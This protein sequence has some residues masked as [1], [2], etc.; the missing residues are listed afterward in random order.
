MNHDITT[1]APWR[2][3]SSH[4]AQVATLHMREL[5]RNSP[6]RAIAFSLEAAGLFLD[7]SK[8]RI[9]PET[10]QRLLDLARTADVEGQRDAM[11]AGAI[12]NNTERRAVLHTALRRPASQALVLD[13]T[14]IMPG[15]AEVQRRM[16]GLVDALAGG[17]WRGYSGQRITDVVNIGIGGSHLG[18]CMAT[19]ALR[20]HHRTGLRV[21]YV[22]N[23]D[24][25]DLSHTLA[26]LHPESTLFIVVSKTFTTQETS[27][28]AQAARNWLLQS[29]GDGRAV[30]S[31]MIAVTSNVEAAQRFGIEP[32]NTFEMWEWVGGRY[33]LWSAVGLSTACAVGGDAFAEMLAGAYA[34]DSH[35]Q[36]APLEMNM[37]VALALLGV[38]YHNFF[39]AESLCVVPYDESL[40]HFPAY[41]QQLDMESNG[42]RVDR[43]GR[44]VQT[45]TGPV[46]WGGTGTNSQHAF[47]QLLHQGGRL[48]PLDLLVGLRNPRPIADQHDIL[49]ANCIAQAEALMRGRTL[50]ETRREMRSSGVEEG[51]IEQL[52]PHRVFPGN[53]PSNLIVYPELTPR[54]LGALIALY[55]HKVFVQGAIWGLNSFDQWGVELGKQLAGTVLRELQG[56]AQV[57]HDASTAALV[58]LYRSRREAGDAGD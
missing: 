24:P 6:E 22:S 43:A 51:R 37:P 40:R 54:V 13:G 7:Y 19:D 3:L 14:N 35:F 48:V 38:W 8:N 25:G 34:M 2:A 21:H 26:T 47:F 58:A 10:M 45:S 4:H 39:G 11:L 20:A 28:N 53:R 12:I 1:S 52:A 46:L 56:G 50:D 42:K 57:E 23:V 27:A 55:E 15:I 41:L 5:F 32:A 16:R 49:V 9:V 33:S 44:P 31:H 29:F 17:H 30:A 36:Q 18:P